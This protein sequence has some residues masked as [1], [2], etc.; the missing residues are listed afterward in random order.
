M[1]KRK[2]P[3]SLAKFIRMEKAK[4]RRRTNQKEAEEK[5]IKELLDRVKPL[6]KES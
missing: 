5:L 6:T 1:G 4:I 3:R 2:Y